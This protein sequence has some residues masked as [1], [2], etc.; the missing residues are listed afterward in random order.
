MNINFEKVN[1]T[2]QAEIKLSG[3]SAIHIERTKPG[4]FY[5]EKSHS[6]NGGYVD[7]TDNNKSL[8]RNILDFTVTDDVYPV[9]LRMTSTVPVDLA[10]A[11]DDVKQIGDSIQW[12]KVGNSE[13]WFVFVKND[14]KLYPIYY[15]RKS[16]KWVDAYVSIVPEKTNFAS[17]LAEQYNDD[18]FPLD[19]FFV[20]NEEMD[21]KSKFEQL[22]G[23]TLCAPEE[24]LKSTESLR[25]SF[26]EAMDQC[27]TYETYEL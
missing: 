3:V 16:T 23:Y 1:S 27:E 17:I 22:T 8:M 2:Y 4:I 26:L 20:E 9:Y 19:M 12:V 6:E 15:E 21:I 25:N 14:Q 24:A 13:M 10:M 11:S 7:A 5:I 18:L